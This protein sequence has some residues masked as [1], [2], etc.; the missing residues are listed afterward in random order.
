METPATLISAMNAFAR[1]LLLAGT[2]GLLAG[3][4][5]ASVAMPIRAPVSLAEPYRPQYHFTPATAWMNDPNGLVYY[6]GEYHL[7]YQHNP[8]D[9]VWGP[10]HWGH[11]VSQDLINWQHLPIA[12]APDENG[13][14]PT[15]T[16]R[17]ALTLPRELALR[18]T[19]AGIRLTQRP[20]QELEALRREH[21]TWQNEAITPGANLLADVS[22][23]ALEIIA[24][25]PIS[26]DL[27]ADRVGLR[28]R[29]GDGE[30][31]TIGYVT[32]AQKLYVDRARSGKTDF[33]AGFASPHSADMPPV[34]GLLRLHIFVDRSSVEVFGD[35]GLTVFTESLFPD[36]A[37][38]GLELFAEGGPAV[39][40]SLDIY[41]LNSAAFYLPEAAGE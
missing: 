3:C 24:A 15:S 26:P 40:N 41:A 2:W 8:A 22:G 18:T 27:A 28:L 1:G 10:M 30:A 25:I 29:A 5:T 13:A 17:G 7:F 21:W 14:I 11:A 19:P 31:T 35:D 20:I 4:Q 34:A 12:L 38:L 39:L 37:S 6:A 36:A 16:W 33:S 23:E 32:R 9:V